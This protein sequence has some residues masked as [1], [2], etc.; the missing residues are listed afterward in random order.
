[1]L[2]EVTLDLE[3]FCVFLFVCFFWFGCLFL[4][5]RTLQ[6]INYN[7]LGNF[8]LVLS[9]DSGVCSKVLDELQRFLMFHIVFTQIYNV[10]CRL[11][12]CELT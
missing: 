12:I 6:S 11:F 7:F 3:V 2:Y 1:M 4:W 8:N 10:I 9:C 5:Q